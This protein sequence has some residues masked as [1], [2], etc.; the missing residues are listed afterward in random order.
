MSDRPEIEFYRDIVDIAHSELPYTERLLRFM[1]AL[2][3]ANVRPSTNELHSLIGYTFPDAI[4]I[5]QTINQSPNQ[6]PNPQNPHPQSTTT[7]E[8][9]STQSLQ[10]TQATEASQTTSETT[11]TQDTQNTQIT[12]E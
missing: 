11:H 1:Q 5:Q 6:S 10:S 2:R 4:E 3:N 9:Q 8:T 12:S 7:Q